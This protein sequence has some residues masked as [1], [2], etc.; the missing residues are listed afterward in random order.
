VWLPFTELTSPLFISNKG[1]GVSPEDA[2]EQVCVITDDAKIFM[3]LAELVDLQKERER[4]EKELS[5]ARAA[6]EAQE[7]KL[8]NEA[9][10]SKAPEAV[11]AAE[12]EKL[13]KA[14]ALI[15]NIKESLSGLQG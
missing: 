15:E 2:D 11:V 3:P 10:V 13:E 7:K 8:S 1:R 12:R 6:L 4:L 9:F 5:K 14:K